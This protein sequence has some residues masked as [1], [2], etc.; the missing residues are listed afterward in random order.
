MKTTG[1]GEVNIYSPQIGQSQSVDRSM[2]LWE[3]SIDVV[4]Q[5]RQVYICQLSQGSICVKRAY[6]AVE[7]ILA[8]TKTAAANAAVVAVV[9]RLALPILP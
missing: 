1:F 3:V 4:I 6:L 2:H 9:D 7:E 5:A 8:Q